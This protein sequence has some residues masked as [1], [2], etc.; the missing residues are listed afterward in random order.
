MNCVEKTS[1]PTHLTIDSPMCLIGF[2]WN[3]HPDYRLIFG[4]N[5]DELHDRPAAPAAWWSDHPQI[6]AGLD[7]KAGGSWMGATRRDRFA[8]VTD[9][10][11]PVTKSRRRVHAVNW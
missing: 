8:A 10:A 5:R 7:L 4:A 1:G 6:L 9:F 11:I 2:A 3:A